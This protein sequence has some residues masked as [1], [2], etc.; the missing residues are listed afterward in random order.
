MPQMET[1]PRLHHQ[2]HQLDE[3]AELVRSRPLREWPCG[4]KVDPVFPVH[5]YHPDPK[6][7]PFVARRAPPPPPHPPEAVS[8]AAKPDTA[9]PS[10]PRESEKPREAADEFAD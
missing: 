10:P 3:I 2:E 8:P 4:A 9:T 6:R 5:L 1:S 7:G